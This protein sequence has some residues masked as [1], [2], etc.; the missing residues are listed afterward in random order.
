MSFF[1]RL[2]LALTGGLRRGERSVFVRYLVAFSL[3]GMSTWVAMWLRPDTYRFPYLAYY[4]AILVSLLYGGLGP[5]LLA[6]VLSALLVDYF[7]LPPYGQFGTDPFGLFGGFYFCLSFGLICWLIDTRWR[8]TEGQLETQLRLLDA[9]T[10]PVIMRDTQDRIIYWNKGAEEVYGWTR[11]EAIGQ[12]IAELL[13]T[14]YPGPTAETNALLESAG[15]WSGEL[16]R[17]KRDG[18]EVLVRSCLD[19]RPGPPR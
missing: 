7:F 3:I 12:R 4:A 17:T 18:I 2:N 19:S 10:E 5:G 14:E 9:A 15:Q 13:H 16:K 8:R 11:R 6:T 1:E